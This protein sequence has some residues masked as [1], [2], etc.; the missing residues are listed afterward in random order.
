MV[1]P[2]LSSLSSNMEQMN[3]DGPT[4]SSE[5]RMTTPAKS[6]QVYEDP[7][8]AGDNTT[9]RP[10]L[11]TPVLEE[12]PV[13]EDSVNQ[14]STPIASNNVKAGL[15]SPEK[16]RQNSRLLDSGISK[17]KAHALDVHGFRKLQSVVKDNNK[18]VWTDIR[19]EA[20][21]LGLFEYL[22]A[23]LD[24][25]SV[26]KAE[27]VKTQVLLTITLMLKKDRQQFASY[28]E[29][30]IDSLLVAR[31]FFHAKAHIVGGLDKLATEMVILGDSK[32]IAHTI[33]RR[34]QAQDMTTEG[35]RSLSM[36]MQILKSMMSGPATY[37]PTDEQAES[38]ASLLISCLESSDSGVRMAAVKV[39]VALHTKIGGEAFWRI[40][41]E[42]K[43]D[44]KNLIYY[45]I[46]KGQKEAAVAV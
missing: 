12:L 15:L 34:L 14:Q 19:F 24:N 30:G 37:T 44:P 41:G 27:D 11:S 10:V 16:T 38:I 6:L 40:M 43:Q 13:N 22:E 45:Y 26:E 35:C 31:S 29:K 20:L 7:F 8:S 39:A 21:T 18:N 32:D 5:P 1:I 17:V 25:L 9:P 28:V 23:P 42:V 46:E 33:L 2:K 4:K 36:G 3:L